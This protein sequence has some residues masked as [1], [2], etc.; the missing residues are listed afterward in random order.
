M[1]QALQRT[2]MRDLEQWNTRANRKP[3]LLRG[4]RQTGKT[5]IVNTFGAAH[6]NNVARI[7]FMRDVDARALFDG[8]LSPSS[9]T[10][11]ISI[12]T[13]ESI[14]PQH[15]LIFFDEIQEC[16]RALTSLKY[17]CED[18]PEYHVIA[19]GSY[20]GISRHEDA[21]FP[22]GKVDM[23][24]LHPLTFSEFLANAGEKQL[25]ELIDT[26]HVR[27]IPTAFT[28]RL[29]DHLKMYMF[30]G[31]MPAVVLDY[32]NGAT[33]PQTR[34]NQREILDSYDLDFSK[35]AP[36]RL[37]ERIRLV[38]QSLPAQL[39]KENRRFVYGAVRP[40]A[41]AREFEESLMW[42]RDYGIIT[43]VG[44]TSALRIPLSSYAE[45]AVFKLFASDIGLLGALASLDPKVVTDGSAL[46][47]EFKG[48]FTE[49]LVCQQLVAQQ[50]TPFYWANPRGQAEVDFA[51]EHDGTLYPIEVKASVNLHAKSLRV[52]CEKFHLDHALRIALTDFRDEGWLTNFPLWAC[53]GLRAYLDAN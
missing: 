30:V 5:W 47:T 18:A 52:A 43:Q 48:S 22:V 31:G 23:L 7:D 36:S 21:S 37:L 1:I 50:F 4:A 28:S 42:L 40:G 41:R 32:L 12:Y 38:W 27:D 46:F 45:P 39:A 14:D 11:N 35:H 15:T 2:I 6:F 44:C 8:N 34:M 24:R 9:L 49:Q 25:S 29:V 3:L 51:L 19:T 17:W 13:G 10:R 26:G 20:M 53:S 16:P 33:L